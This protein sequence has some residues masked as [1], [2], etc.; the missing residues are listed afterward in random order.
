MNKNKNIYHT[1]D[2]ENNTFDDL[3]FFTF[4]N[5]ITKCKVVDIYDGD[6]ITIVFYHNDYPIKCRLRLYGYDSPEIKPY[7][8]LENREK[9]IEAGKKVKEILKEKIL[10]KIVWVKFFEE[11][12]YGRAMGNI[13]LIDNKDKM[14]GK[15]ICINEWI[16][17]NNYGKEYKGGKKQNFTE[18]ELDDIINST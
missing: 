5:I 11:E 8:S 17:K 10:N 14:S 18:K 15:E 12:K 2:L 4:K 6:T 16:V 1:Q 13:Y 3:D 7:K 9:N